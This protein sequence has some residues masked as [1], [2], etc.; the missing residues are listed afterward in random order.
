MHDGGIALHHVLDPWGDVL[1]LGFVGGPAL[2]DGYGVA[3][4]VH[5]HGLL[6]RPSGSKAG[7][8]VAQR[9][10]VGIIYDVHDDEGHRF[11]HLPAAAFGQRQI[12]VVGMVVASFIGAHPVGLELAS[13]AERFVPQAYLVVAVAAVHLVDGERIIE[14]WRG[15][16]SSPGEVAEYE[17]LVVIN[18]CSGR[19]RWSAIP[20]VVSVVGVGVD[21]V[22]AH[23]STVG[24]AQHVDA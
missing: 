3:Y 9:L 10:S 13:S 22:V 17:V 19:F 5:S 23:H 20:G 18:G 21:G 7:L 16:L 1:A 6:E 14:F 11:A 8:V 15:E 2:R 12:I 4:G 24:R